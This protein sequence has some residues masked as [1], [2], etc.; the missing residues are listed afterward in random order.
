MSEPATM[1]EPAADARASR[2]ARNRF[3]LALAAVSLAML[4]LFLFEFPKLYQLWCKATG[5]QQN[6]NNAQAA[7]APAQATGRFIDVLFEGVPYNDLPVRFY[8]DQPELKVEVGVDTWNT[9]HFKNVSDHTVYF[10]PVHQ[11]SPLAA[12]LYFGMKVC[13]CFN[14]QE[15]PAGETRDFPVAFTFSPDLDP[16]INTVTI[17]YGLFPIEP[18]APLTDDQKRLQ[19]KL[20]GGD[21][22]VVTPG[23]ATQVPSGKGR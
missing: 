11:V 2:P 17:R 19:E 5:T 18:G 12:S 13:F 20:M 9:Y 4:A 10:R 23:A 3:R 16:R 15:I 8:P 14:N 1:A 7:A 6:P 21:G 22:G